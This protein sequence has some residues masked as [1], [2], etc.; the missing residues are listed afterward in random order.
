MSTTIQSNSSVVAPNEAETR[1]ALAWETGRRQPNDKNTWEWL[2]EAIQGDFNDN[3]S[4][5][6]IAFDSAISMIPVVDQICD[7]RDIIANCRAIT[8]AQ[9]GQDKTWSGVALVLTLIGLFPSLGSLVKG[10]LK[11]FFLFVR[12]YGGNQV[13]KAVDDAMTWVITFLRKREV[14]DYLRRH[15]VDDVFKWLADQIRKV[16]AQVSAAV[17]LAAFDK[18]IAVMR[19]LLGKVTW[20][21]GTVGRRAQATIDMVLSVRKQI[22]QWIGGALVPVQ[23]VLHRV[24]WRLD[25]ESALQRS[26]IVNARNVHFRGALPEARAIGLMKT[27]TPRPSWLSAGRNVEWAEQNLRSG[28]AAVQR[29]MED[30]WCDLSDQNI[31][32]FHSMRAVAINGP[33]KLY[34][35]TSPSNGAMGDCWIPEDV[36]VKIVNSP[37]PKAAWRKYLAVWPDW[38]PDSQFVVM[39][40]P[41]GQTMKVWRGPAASQVKP[42]TSGLSAHLEG[43]W[44]QIIFKVNGTDFDTTR[45]FMRGGGHGERLHTPGLTREEWSKLTPSK[46]AAYTPVRERINHDGIR[47]PFDTGWGATDFDPQLRDARIGLPALPGQVTNR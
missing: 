40:I 15:K 24:I 42:E 45:Y 31:K 32:S 1:A 17:V 30:G 20:L 39:E 25:Y 47:G 7:V 3:R 46:R 43:G 5:G 38:N 41:A 9:E 6:Q 44:D 34:R 16:K 2:W 36:W 11:I 21:P 29:K 27:T 28:R 14:Q 8:T 33:A 22:D 12:R 10:V 18:G 37:D 13:V 26:A 23:H 19:S 35:V 4:T